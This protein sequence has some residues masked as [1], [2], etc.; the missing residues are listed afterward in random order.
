M[1]ALAVELRFEHDHAL[2]TG[3]DPR[4]GGLQQ[5]RE[6]AVEQL[7]LL[8]EDARRPL[9]AV[10]DLLAL[11]E[12]ERHV[13]AGTVGIGVQLLGE[14]QQH[15]EPA[16]HVGGAET[17]QHVA[18]DRGDGV[19]VGG[20][21]VEVTAEHDPAVAPELRAG[22]HAGADASRSTGDGARDC[23]RSSTILA[24]SASWWLSDGTA[25]SA[26][27]SPKRSVASRSTDG[28][29]S[30]TWRSRGRAGCR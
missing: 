18:V 17:V 21:G 22:D 7:G 11:V 24:S 25:T 4:V 20:H 6:V 16:L 5:H 14:A 29:A 26:A 15:R 3:L 8:L 10:G 19:A 9:N 28:D 23:S 2:A 27:V 12:R 1:G 30:V 13:E